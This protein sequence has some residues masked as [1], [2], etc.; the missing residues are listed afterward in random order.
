VGD[1]DWL[2]ERDC[3]GEEDDD[4]DG[5]DVIDDVAVVDL[6]PDRLTV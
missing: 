1:T 5:V 4:T 2:A 3:V 6:V